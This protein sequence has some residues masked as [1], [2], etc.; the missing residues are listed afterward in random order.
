MIDFI[1]S[2]ITRPSDYLR[3]HE[4]VQKLVDERLPKEGILHDLFLD[5]ATIEEA[6]AEFFANQE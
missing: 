1:K 6:L 5:G 3:W 2:E 4:E